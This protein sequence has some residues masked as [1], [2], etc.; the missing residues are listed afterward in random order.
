MTDH[1]PEAVPPPGWYPDPNGQTRW[2]DGSAWGQVAAP[3]QGPSPTDSRNLAMLAQLLGIFTGFL[4][5]LIIYLM[6]AKKD[7]FVRHHASEALNFQITYFIAVM[8]SVLAMLLLIGFL[9]LPVVFVAG[10][11]FQIQG[12]VAANRGEWWRFPVNIRMVPG[13]NGT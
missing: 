4:G 5:P 9:L 13:E 6:N 3:A 12:A 1:T 10:L 2:W 8:V 7:P 11:V